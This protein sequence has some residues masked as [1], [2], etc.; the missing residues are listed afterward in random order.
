MC[1]GSIRS[2]C[3][4]EH[5]FHAELW[6]GSRDRE[7]KISVPVEPRTPNGQELVTLNDLPGERS[8]EKEVGGCKRKRNTVRAGSQER[9][10]ELTTHTR[11][12]ARARDK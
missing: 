7:N 8:T 2:E 10:L 9:A 1:A 11:R 6:I 3:T 4:V 5:I 12:K